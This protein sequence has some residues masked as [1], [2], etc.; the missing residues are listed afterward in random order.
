MRINGDFDDSVRDEIAEATT[1]RRR[2]RSTNYDPAAVF[3]KP[4]CCW[5]W[6]K[7]QGKGWVPVSGAAKDV[8]VGASGAIWTVGTNPVGGGFSVYKWNGTG[9]TR[10]AGAASHMPRHGLRIHMVSGPRS[11]RSSSA[12]SSSAPLR[13]R[14]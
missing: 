12:Q 10:A 1:P 8:A 9:W 14:C 7:P 5:A 2:L 3:M 6:F 11:V 13:S 4:M